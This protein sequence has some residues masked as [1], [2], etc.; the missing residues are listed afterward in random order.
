MNTD[1][2]AL[3]SAEQALPLP[4]AAEARTSVGRFSLANA[5][6]EDMQR[7]GRALAE[8]GY[9]KDVRDVA[10]ACAKLL[11]GQELGLTLMETLTGLRFVEGKIEMAPHLM[12]ARINRLAEQGYSYKVEWIGDLDE[13]DDEGDPIVTGCKIRYFRHDVELGI[14]KFTL[15][16]AM[17]ASLAT[18]D[19]YKK[20]G[21]NMYYARAMSNGVKWYMSEVVGGGQVYVIGEIAG[22]DFSEQAVYVV[23]EQV[24]VERAAL[25]PGLVSAAS[26]LGIM[27]R[28]IEED[29][30]KHNGDAGAVEALYAERVA[31]KQPREKLLVAETSTGKINAQSVAEALAKENALP[32]PAPQT[33]PPQEQ[34]IEDDLNDFAPRQAVKGLMMEFS[35]PAAKALFPTREARMA[36]T[37]DVIKR[38]VASSNDLYDMELV[39]VMDEL[40]KRIA[41]N[42]PVNDQAMDCPACGVA[43]GTSHFASCDLA[44]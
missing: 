13:L 35:R 3:P 20:Y 14:S 4:F 33:L 42:G 21:R 26:V 10:Q 31:K 24:P 40:R 8:C 22:K 41:S 15:A 34:A 1:T 43:P 9:Y 6:F 19:N 18:K 29:L 36:F 5:S 28:G 17:R 44:A 27:P 37:R 38:D 16:D 7:I 25:P 11:A 2:L 32:K 23:P 30:K 39:L 12:A